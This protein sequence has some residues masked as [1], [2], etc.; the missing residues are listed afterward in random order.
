VKVYSQADVLNILTHT[1]AGE[2]K[3][4][5]ETI[6]PTLGE[7][8]VLVN[9]TGL[10]MLPY[11][12]TATGTLFHLG[13]VLVS[14]SRVRIENGTEGYAV[15]LGRDLQQSIAVALLDAAW[16]ANLAHEQILSFVNEQAEN[17]RRADDDL[18][19]QVEATRVELETF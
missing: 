12:D 4:L 7:I 2:V 18:L 5:A 3:E 19:K 16:Q 10:I 14:E 13:E 1:P 15:C 6:L 8:T 11:T 17:Q 9:R